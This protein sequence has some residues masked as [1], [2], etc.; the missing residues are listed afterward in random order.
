MTDKLSCAAH[1]FSRAAGQSKMVIFDEHTVIESEAMIAPTTGSDCILFQHAQPRRRLARVHDTCS[2]IC[3]GIH[4]AMRECGDAGKVLQ[5][6]ER[7]AL[8]REQ[9]L[10]FAA[11]ARK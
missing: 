8:D 1:R 10:R 2:G 11:Q 5:E 3:Y 4:V 6:V 7:D 9:D